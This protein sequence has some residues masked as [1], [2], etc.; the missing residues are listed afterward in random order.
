MGNQNAE[1]PAALTP[2]SPTTPAA[3]KDDPKE[4][5]ANSEAKA[6]KRAEE[7]KEPAK[8][9]SEEGKD[10]EP[11]EKGDYLRKYQIRK[12]TKPGSIQSDPP[13]GSKAAVMKAHLLAQPTKTI[14]INRPDGEDK[15][16]VGT[17]NLDGYRLDFKKDSYHEFPEQVADVI[18]DSQ[19]QTRIALLQ[20]QIGQDKAKENALS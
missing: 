10:L 6:V 13:A 1:E 19:G 7:A 16:S 20:G 12:N 18:M 5:K 3:P 17:V 8:L 2:A 4:A 15:N 11:A 9:E 14:L